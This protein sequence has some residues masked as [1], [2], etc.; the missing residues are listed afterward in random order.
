VRN[1]SIAMT[2]TP[3]GKG[4]WVLGADGG[5][6][7]FGDAGFYGSVPGLGL[8][9]PGV[10]MRATKSG[11]GYYVLSERGDVF[12]FGDAPGMGSPA[13]LGIKGQD[14]AVTA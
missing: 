6:F 4:Y 8:K 5:I 3:S 11:G 10:Q 14:L 12:A 13:N 2:P 7:T 9:V 1:T